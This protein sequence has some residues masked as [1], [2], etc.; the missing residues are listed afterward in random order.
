MIICGSYMHKFSVS[1]DMKG[2]KKKIPSDPPPYLS[3]TTT[4]KIPPMPPPLNHKT[5]S[6][7]SIP[8]TRHQH[9]R[10]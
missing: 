9:S 1:K 6:N 5:I 10:Y 7:S 3:P 4:T 8:H 2:K